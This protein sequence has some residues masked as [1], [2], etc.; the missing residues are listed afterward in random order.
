MYLEYRRPFRVSRKFPRPVI[1]IDGK[2]QQAN[3]IRIT[4]GPV[5]SGMKVCFTH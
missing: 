3:L 2:L 1:K 4:N 5:T